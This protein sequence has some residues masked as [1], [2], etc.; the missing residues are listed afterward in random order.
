MTTNP[1]KKLSVPALIVGCVA[2]TFLGWNVICF[3]RQAHTL[4]YVDSAIV[5]IRII[6]AQETKFARVH[7]DT[8]YTCTLSELPPHEVIQDLMKDVRRNGYVFEITGCS[9][10]IGGRPNQ[11]YQVTARPMQ[12][13]MPVFCSDQSGVLRSDEGGS[14][15]VCLQSGPPR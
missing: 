5:S 1:E 14:P 12:A 2:V 15:G 10:E 7:P 11:T 4:G 8:G 6:N 3:V 9:G 13:N